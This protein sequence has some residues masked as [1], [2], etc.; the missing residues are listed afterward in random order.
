MP[1]KPSTTSLP[2]FGRLKDSVE[3]VG[4]G[5]TLM[6]S[7]AKEHPDI[8]RKINTATIVDYAKVD[9]ILAAMPEAKIGKKA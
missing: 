7:L 2:R 4:V 1:Q 9:K 8:F 6:Y 3:R 5:R